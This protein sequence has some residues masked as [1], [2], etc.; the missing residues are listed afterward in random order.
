MLDVNQEI[1][2]NS[3]ALATKVKNRVFP[4]QWIQCDLRSLDMSILGKFSVVM[5]GKK[6]DYIF[7]IFISGLPFTSIYFACVW[8]ICI[9]KPC[10]YKQAFM[11]HNRVLY[12][13]FKMQNFDNSCYFTKK[14]CEKIYFKF[15]KYFLFKIRH[16]TF[17]WSFHMAQW[18]MTR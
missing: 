3:Q 16:G 9:K 5:A 7:V 2:Q 1:T 14:R 17:T 13:K 12:D 18:L 11:V 6:S 10:A 15:K 8:S 4:P